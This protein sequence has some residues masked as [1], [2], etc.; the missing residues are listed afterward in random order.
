[1]VEGCQWPR[2]IPQYPARTSASRTPTNENG[3][4]GRRGDSLAH[5]EVEAGGVAVLPDPGDLDGWLAFERND[6]SAEIPD[7]RLGDNVHGPKQRTA[8]W[9]FPEKALYIRLGSYTL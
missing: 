4:I 3:T 8:S 2:F 7:G 1:M 6:S 5:G 9:Q